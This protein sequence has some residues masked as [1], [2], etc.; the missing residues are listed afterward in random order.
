MKSQNRKSLQTERL[1]FLIYRMGKEIA[2]AYRVKLK[3]IGAKPE[4]A[5]ILSAISHRNMHVRELSRHLGLNRQSL[6]N[7]VAELVA[8]KGVIRSENKL[9]A[10]LV[11]ISITKVGISLLKKIDLI[12]ADFDSELEGKLT[13]SETAEANR[14]LLKLAQNPLVNSKSLF[15]KIDLKD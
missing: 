14:I 3:K 12:S 10:R 6:L 13:R 2:S 7:A 1:G 4:Y 11:E 5:G 9:D 8:M 15:D